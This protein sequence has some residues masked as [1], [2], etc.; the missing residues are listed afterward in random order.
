MARAR[1]SLV[2]YLVCLAHTV[3]AQYTGYDYGFDVRTR[4]KRQLGQLQATVVQD[5]SGGDIYVR[6][7]IRQLEQDRDVW[8]LYILGLSMMQFT[9]Q[10][11][12]TSYYGIAGIH[13]M[14]HQTWGGVKPVPGSEDTGYCTHSSVLF[15][16]WHRPYMA[17]YEELIQTIAGFWPAPERQ[18]YQDAARR[19][20][21][22]YWD[23]AATP[24]SGES[25]LPRSIGGS[26]YV[27]VEGPNGLQRIANPL[28]SYTFKPLNTTAFNYRPW[29]Y[30]TR[31][32][33][34][35]SSG[36]PDAQSNNSQ[37]AMNLDQNRPSIAQ[38]LYTLFSSYDNYTTFSNNA[39][40]AQADSIEALHDTIHTL[41]GGFGSSVPNPGHMAFIQWSAFDPIFFLH[42]CMVDRVLAIWQALHPDAWVTPSPALVKS[43]TTRQG[44]IQD[45]NSPLTPFFSHEN[46]TFW[47]SAEVRDHTKFG[48]TYPELERAAASTADK[49]VSRVTVQ[50]VNRLYGSFSPASLFLKEL[51]AQGFKGDRE[52][53]TAGRGTGRT[54]DLLPR[55]FSLTE[56]K[57]FVGDRY[58][59]WVANVRVGTQALDGTFVVHFFLGDPPSDP[60]AWPSAPN[61]VGTMGVFAA[62]R[63]DNR[64]NEGQGGRT[65]MGAHGHHDLAVSGTVPLTAALVK[66]VAAGELE[67]LDPADVEPYLRANLQ[68]RVLGPK[69]E[70]WAGEECML[71]MGIQ[72]VDSQV[73]AP[74]N[75]EELPEW[76]EAK[77]SFEMC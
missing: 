14:P 8:T 2:L 33:R 71:D 22:P 66:K 6:Q 51:R 15:P 49:T 40:G 37:V 17:L 21:I 48:Y 67:S 13:G 7:E 70:I 36:G 73:R 75:E 63:E 58:H 42:H 68:R 28:F 34:S 46:G 35:P 59:E 26:P 19:F 56:S 47:T 5:K 55:S 53:A 41:T 3:L 61:H 64:D 24:P 10:S 23:W 69:G 65:E 4:M 62:A 76:G 29:N 25:V 44:Q 32:L 1:L 16:T 39:W 72:I 20:R 38:R 30:W 57:I 27:D 9:D 18:R 11:S 31:T 60:Q 77:V 74:Y 43:Y 45:A 50:A 12:P 54:T 52:V